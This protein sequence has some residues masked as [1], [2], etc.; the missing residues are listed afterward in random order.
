MSKLRIFSDPDSPTIIKE[1]VIVIEDDN[2]VLD[3]IYNFTV[4]PILE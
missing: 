3:D 2:E 1:E 4:Q